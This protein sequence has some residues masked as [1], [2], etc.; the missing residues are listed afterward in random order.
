MYIPAI[1]IMFFKKCLKC[2]W[3]TWGGS[4]LI[5]VRVF[6]LFLM[7]TFMIYFLLLQAILALRYSR[8]KGTLHSSY[9]RELFFL[10]FCNVL[11]FGPT[12]YRH[13]PIDDDDYIDVLFLGQRPHFIWTWWFVLYIGCKPIVDNIYVCICFV[14]DVDPKAHD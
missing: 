9:N 11:N 2:P 10:I 8:C 4:Y 6:F 5:E 7:N 14:L 13:E 3:L 12:I 1:H